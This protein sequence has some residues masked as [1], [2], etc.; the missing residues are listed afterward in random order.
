MK[1]ALLLYLAVYF[2]ANVQEEAWLDAQSG[3]RLEKRDEKSLPRHL[4]L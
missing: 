4:A 3:R 1:S 2:A